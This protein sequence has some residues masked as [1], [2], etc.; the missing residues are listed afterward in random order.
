MLKKISSLL[1]LI[2]V[3]VSS[4][5]YFVKGNT[6]FKAKHEQLIDNHPFQKYLKLSKTERKLNNLPPNKYYQQERI[7][8]MDP[9]TGKTYPDRLLAL[10]EEL[11]SRS[12]YNRGVPGQDAA[13]A[14]VERGPNNVPG[15]TRAMMYDPND[16]N[17]KRVFA[18]GVTGGL[19]V[20]DD[21]ENPNSVWQRVD[22]PENLVVS[23]IT[24]DVNNSNVFYVGTGEPYV[25]GEGTGNGVWKSTDGGITW[26]HIF[27]G[28]SGATSLI[29]NA[30]LTI[31][32]PASI[33]GDYVAVKAAFGPSLTA[34]GVSGD[35]VLAD[36][37]GS[38]LACNNFGPT[39]TN[40]IAL[41]D[42]GDCFFVDKVKNAQLAGAV[43]VIV[44]QSLPDF[45]FTM[46]GD[47]STITIPSVMIS[48]SDGELL[49]DQIT[50]G[51]TINATIK[52]RDTGGLPSGIR[53]VPGKFIVNDI[54]TRNNNNVT[55][56][57]AAITET[58]HTSIAYV[59]GGEFGI[60]KSTDD[61]NSWIKLDLPLTTDGNPHPINDLYIAPDNTIYA[62]SINSYSYRDSDDNFD[63]G[64]KVF[65]STDGV[66]F[67][68]KY[69]IP[70]GNRVEIA[71]S[72][73]NSNKI[74]I[75]CYTTDSQVKIYKSNFGFQFPP[76]SLPVPND[77]SSNP[78]NDF[79]NG[80]GWYDLGI[81]VDP[82][83]DNIVY[84]AG[85]ST[86]KSTNSGASWVKMS[87]AYGSHPS[88]SMHADSHNI[89][90][91]PTDP[92]KG[93]I[94][95]DGGVYYVS[96]FSNAQTNP[97][98]MQSRGNGYNTT[99]FYKGAISQDVNSEKFLGGAQDN[100]TNF[101]NNAQ[102][103]INSSSE[104]GGADG[105]FCFIDKDGQY[106]ISS[107]YQN[108]YFKLDINGNFLST[109]VNNQNEGSFVNV[110]ELDDNLDILFSNASNFDTQNS[111]WNINISR[112]DLNSGNARTDFTDPMITRPPTAMRV[113]PYTTNSS[114]LFIGTDSG[115]IYKVTNADT[116]PVWTDLTPEAYV[117]SFSGSISSIN[118]GANEDEIIV[119]FHNYGVVNVY[120]TE[121]GGQTW[122]N[123]EGNLP[124]LPVKDVLMNPLNN[125]EVILATD[126][127]VW[128]TTNFKS[129][130]PNWHRSQNGMQNVKVTSFDLR[131]S[132]NTVLASTYGRGFFTGQFNAD[133]NAVEQNLVNN[134]LINIFPTVS[135]GD[136]NIKSNKNIGQVD[137]SI[138]NVR[139]QLVNKHKLDLGIGLS[140]FSLNLKS[141]VYF[142]KIN[143]DK[144]NYSQMI[145]I[146]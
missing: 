92:N 73:T 74:Y 59:V 16:S 131:T 139:G 1:L 2:V 125:E 48:K 81:A 36:D 31:N 85:I 62:G 140:D 114:T 89:V 104:V 103:G 105:M 79:T 32:S 128:R 132:D 118:F 126:L 111:S 22:I 46:G 38:T 120:F 63:G 51:V 71:G 119:T 14:W 65:K 8:E 82:T 72:A 64:G 134:D 39:A 135:S 106:M 18:G 44:I 4:I 91:H 99:Q 130:N 60:Y 45:P 56:I 35:L 10:Q 102:P 47:D 129:S 68:E 61:G 33:S 67:T 86:F 6:P 133:V 110:A 87:H 107:I 75:L 3:S 101:I 13:N 145:I 24:A 52:S 70:D 27:G 17:H 15:R 55:E 88:S 37:A 53:L 98:A 124:D 83:N 58:Y 7:L 146:K 69:A 138:F 84:L 9:L 141:G 109:I 113:S 115:S 20:I 123:K 34:T 41:I 76:N 108:A 142:V 121:D 49:K 21:I 23:S 12:T 127:G 40:K 57:Y 29:Y 54:V 25:G 5:T 43:G 30:D 19:W 28:S 97:N 77:P 117:A 26:N 96:N 80:Q 66:T 42:R 90:I 100:G 136:F 144:T 95:N 50:Q 116:N 94:G 93:V 78:Q 112:F 11:N 137:L 143:N 122:Q